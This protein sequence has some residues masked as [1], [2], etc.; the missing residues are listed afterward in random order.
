ME[1]YTKEQILTYLKEQKDIPS[2]VNNIDALGKNLPYVW[3][4]DSKTILFYFNRKEVNTESKMIAKL[5]EYMSSQGWEKAEY[6]NDISM[7]S[8]KEILEYFNLKIEIKKA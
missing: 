7:L 8:H 5:Y 3:C 4:E 1:T 6:C 2:A